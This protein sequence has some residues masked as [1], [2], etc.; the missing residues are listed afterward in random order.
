MISKFNAK[1]AVATIGLLAVMAQAAMAHEFK[2]GAI[3]I[4]HPWSRMTPGGARVGA[5]FM[6]LKNTGKTPDRLLG[7]VSDIAKEVQVHT[8][9][10]KKGVMRMRR[11]KDGLVIAPGATVALKPG[12]FH[13]MF[14]GLKKPIVKG[15]PFKARLKFENGGEVEVSFKVEAIGAMG[16]A[17]EMKMGGMKKMKMPMQMDKKDDHGG[18]GTDTAN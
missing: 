10:M 4:H 3:E 2:A 8:M 5:G 11:L 14:V 6:V 17:D 15:Q 13:I 16:S 12:A 7:G 1:K 9:T 18:S